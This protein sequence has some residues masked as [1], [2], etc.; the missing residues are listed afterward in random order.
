MLRRIVRDT[1]FRGYQ[2]REILQHWGSVRNGEEKNI[3]PFQEEADEMFNSALLYEPAVVRKFCLPIIQRIKK[4]HPEYEETKRL[5]DFLTFFSELDERDVPSNSI[6][7]EFI[8]G[9]SF[10]Y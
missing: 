4:D 9:S 3:Y 2:V 7:R 10:V 8:G 1:Y 5:V 6:L